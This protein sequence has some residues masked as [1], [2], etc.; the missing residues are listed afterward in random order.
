MFLKLQP[1]SALLNAYSKVMIRETA[2]VVE[3][4]PEGIA[5]RFI[6]SGRCSSCA[7]SGICGAKDNSMYIKQVLPHTFKKGDII[8]VEIDEKKVNIA[9]VIAFLIPLV[10]F[11]LSLFLLRNINEAA[12]FFL[13]LGIVLVYYSFVRL[14]LKR[15]ESYFHIKILRKL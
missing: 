3:E 4:L 1:A 2:E 8:E 6:K 5:V 11:F 14:V 13:S 10:I 9:S 15:K 12:N 7:V